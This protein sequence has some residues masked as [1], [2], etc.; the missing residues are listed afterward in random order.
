MSEGERITR[1]LVDTIGREAPHGIGRWPRAWEMVEGPSRAF[2]AATDALERGEGGRNA[3][4]ETGV[5]VREAWQRAALE[6][7][8]CR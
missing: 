8:A 7:E 3:V 2:L 4:V 6:W 5:Q 1:R